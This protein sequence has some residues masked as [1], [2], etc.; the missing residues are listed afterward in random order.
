MKPRGV[1]CLV[2]G[3]SGMAESRGMC[4][5]HYKRSR[6][7]GDPN[8]RTL[9]APPTAIER[10][11]KFYKVDLDTACWEWTGCLLRGYGQFHYNGR[12][13]MAHRVAYELL[14]SP[15]P[16]GLNVLH[17]CDNPS[18]VNP[19]HLYLGTQ[20]DNVNDMWAR[21]R[22]KPG[23]HHGEDHGMAKLRDQEAIA[24]RLSTDTQRSL[25]KRYNLSQSTV[26]A[27]KNRKIWAHL[28]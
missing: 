19:K 11:M 22:A 1:P 26:W 21:G 25:A 8:V 23:A 28:P 20:Q 9:Y 14:V 10:F 16:H 18:C 2:E 6:K 15:M 3:C 13:Y 5:M 12:T 24:I 4:N 27:I 17:R 7:T